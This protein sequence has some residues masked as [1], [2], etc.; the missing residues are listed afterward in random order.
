MGNAI[1]NKYSW[2][3]V[4]NSIQTESK[5]QQAL[6]EINHE[7]TRIQAELSKYRT[8]LSIYKNN[9]LPYLS[10]ALSDYDGFCFNKIKNAYI[11]LDQSYKESNTAEKLKKELKN[12]HQKA[13]QNIK[14]AIE[15]LNNN[16]IARTEELE[17]L[18]AKYN[19]EIQELNRAYANVSRAQTY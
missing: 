15:R 16:V 7:R 17:K 12:E 8:I 13:V 9:V 1:A 6:S 3:R 2:T 14:E 4:S 18:I 11:Y 10:S 5:K 19:N